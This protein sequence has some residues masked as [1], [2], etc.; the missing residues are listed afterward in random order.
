MKDQSTIKSLKSKISQLESKCKADS[1]KISHLRSNIRCLKANLKRKT[2]QNVSLRDKNRRKNTEKTNR[3]MQIEA[4]RITS[5]M[6][7]VGHHFSLELMQFCM[8]LQ[9]VA[10]CSLRGVR[11]VLFAVQLYFNL[12]FEVPSKS[13]I[14]VWSQKIGLFEL[15]RSSSLLID[16]EYAIILDECMVIGTQRM[17]VILGVPACK[18]SDEALGLDSIVI[19]LMES[20][21]SWS[22]QDVSDAID[23][24][25]AKMG[26]RPKY[27]ISDA[28]NNLKSGLKIASVKRIYDVGHH[29]AKLLEYEFKQREDFQRWTKEVAGLRAK[30]FMKDASYLLPPRQ[31][32]TARF[33]NLSETIVWA[34][35]MN[36]KMS[37]FSEEERATYSWLEQYD[38]LIQELD[39]VFNSINKILSVLKCSGLSQ[40]TYVKCKTLLAENTPNM[41]QKLKKSIETYLDNEVTKLEDESSVWHMSSDVI[42]S[43][44]GKMKSRLSLNQLCGVTGNV[45]RL[46]LFTNIANL[47]KGSLS[48]KN[49]KLAM[50]DKTCAELDDWKKKELPESQ[51]VR[52]RNALR[53]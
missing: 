30:L 46:A 10:G 2:E 39:E 51:T 41:P 38:P 42:E 11:K 32:T 9:L 36:E 18:Q 3:T 27:G 45:L 14:D 37:T 50:E 8:I 7:A 6:K 19:L 48:Q 15:N 28:G 22:G 43:L 33:M 25:I 12:D 21:A 24:V 23:R 4:G 13:T 47:E 16:Y 49:I 40:Q 34:K 44:F 5:E 31:R 29:I 17:L 35:K 26:R 52:R 1:D 53:A 20:R